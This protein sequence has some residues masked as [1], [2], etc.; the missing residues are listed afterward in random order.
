[1]I[2]ILM[3]G[4]SAAFDGILMTAL[5]IVK[6]TDRELKIFVATMDLT[7]EDERFSPVSQA[8]IEL[9]D[10]VIKEKNPR[11]EAA[12]L[13][14]GDYYR[15]SLKDSKNKDSRYTPFAMLRLFA[16][17]DSRIPDKILYLDNDLLLSGDIGELYDIDISGYDLAGAKDHYGKVFINPKYINSGVLLLNMK[18]IRES[19]IFKSSVELCMN[20][21][22]LL[23]DQSAINKY[24]KR[25]LFLPARFNEQHKNK[26]DTLIRHFSMR[27]VWFPIFRTENIKPWH[28][29]LVHERLRLFCYDSI[30][31]S[32]REIKEKQTSTK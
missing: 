16:D 17:R 32:F 6:H 21:K 10:S 4:N 26:K 15:E 1:M 12:L 27:I 5:S 7:D 23:P 20:K 24:A 13:D 14:F 18:R 3:C 28:T 22:M 25:K 30:F 11:S 19:G 2:N 8:N 9:L 29:E 31:E